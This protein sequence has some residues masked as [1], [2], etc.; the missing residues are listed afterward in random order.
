MYGD[1]FEPTMNSCLLPA[2]LTLCQGYL[3]VRDD[4]V[5]D[6]SHPIY[7]ALT[8]MEWQRFLTTGLAMEVLRPEV[9]NRD[10]DV[11]DSTDI[12]EDY[13]RLLREGVSTESVESEWKYLDGDQVVGNWNDSKTLQLLRVIGGKT[14][15]R[16]HTTLVA[17][18][19]LELHGLLCGEKDV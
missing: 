4:Q 7:E 13:W 2:I 3:A 1:A 12:R 16:K 17:E 9:I 8:I 10:S 11:G 5:S 6:L 15:D 18:T 19:F 14:G